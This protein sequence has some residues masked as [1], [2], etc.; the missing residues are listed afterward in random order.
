M[1]MALS[2]FFS[3][4]SG[5]PPDPLEV[6]VINSK[7]GPSL[8]NSAS[9]EPRGNN[10]RTPL[11][12]PS[13]TQLAMA[14]AT[15]DSAEAKLAEVKQASHPG[16]AN[17]AQMIKSKADALSRAEALVASAKAA[18]EEAKK[19]NTNANSV[20]KGGRSK[21]I[22]LKMKRKKRAKSFRY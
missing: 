7:T 8:H 5:K 3:S 19:A 2:R 10:V 21:K 9:E 20:S 16:T 17:N 14:K 15:L 22:K 12:S 13:N 6:K 11:L 4:L 18:F 1:G